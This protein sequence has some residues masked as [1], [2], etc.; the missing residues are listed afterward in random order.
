MSNDD[1]S[2][3]D[4]GGKE[5][6]DFGWFLGTLSAVAIIA[7]AVLMASVWFGLLGGAEK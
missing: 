5:L 7:S 4:S 3:G 6:E 1:V 2:N